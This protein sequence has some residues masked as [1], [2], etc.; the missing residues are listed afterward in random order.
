ML[1]WTDCAART[2]EQQ[3]IFAQLEILRRLNPTRTV[4]ALGLRC[5]EPQ[6]LERL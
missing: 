3:I 5:R 6:D 1:S 4:A 2:P